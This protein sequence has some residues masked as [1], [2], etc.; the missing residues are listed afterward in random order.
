M[1]NL[2]FKHATEMPRV[3]S[4]AIPNKYCLTW[5]VILVSLAVLS[6]VLYDA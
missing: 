2:D 1:P 3:T 5:V 4:L 6:S